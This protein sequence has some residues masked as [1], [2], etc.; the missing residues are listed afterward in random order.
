MVD[1]AGVLS[2][3]SDTARSPERDLRNR[4]FL[5]VTIG[6]GATTVIAALLTTVWLVSNGDDKARVSVSQ[7]VAE[8]IPVAI[9]FSPIAPSPVIDTHRQMP[10]RT[11]EGSN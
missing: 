1:Q 11:G 5:G 8:P 3:A 7:P 2:S 9:E 6:A 4:L 10:M